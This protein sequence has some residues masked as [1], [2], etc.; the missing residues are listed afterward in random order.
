MLPL[1]NSLE[2]LWKCS[3][4]IIP[5]KSFPLDPS[6]LMGGM[7][8]FVCTSGLHFRSTD[9]DSTTLLLMFRLIPAVDMVVII[10]NGY[11]DAPRLMGNGFDNIQALDR[12]SMIH[13]YVRS[14][15]HVVF[16]SLAEWHN[17]NLRDHN[18]YIYI[19][20][21]HYMYIC[22]RVNNN[23]YK[24]YILYKITYIII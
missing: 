5:L 10:K 22:T 8:I 17:S 11:W 2:T 21:P 19:C 18:V 7:N 13:I 1:K 20:F 16:D 15:S 9:D 4:E 24:Y 23:M 12:R 3:L 6:T 14:T